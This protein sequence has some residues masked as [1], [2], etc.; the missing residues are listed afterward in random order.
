MPYEPRGHEQAAAQCRSLAD[1]LSWPQRVLDHWPTPL[2]A[3]LWRLRHEL[4]AG[5]TTD[6]MLQLKDVAELLIKLPVLLATRLL[7]DHG[8]EEQ[9]AQALAFL[10]GLPTPTLGRWCAEGRRFAQQAR[11]LEQ[12]QPW[13][14]PLALANW[15]RSEPCKS[16]DRLLSRRR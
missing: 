13:W 10:L 9:R 1:R 11:A 8:D 12:A 7:A 2:A 16:E 3:E 4:Q 15:V 5:R 14:G 6:A